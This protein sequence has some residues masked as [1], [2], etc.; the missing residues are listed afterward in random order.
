MRRDGY[1]SVKPNNLQCDANGRNC[2][3]TGA[4]EGTATAAGRAR[5]PPP[6]AG[7]GAKDV[8]DGKFLRE[9]LDLLRGN[10]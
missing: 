5:A 2:K 1:F 7:L 10:F 8:A 6:P 9:D 4:A 3:F